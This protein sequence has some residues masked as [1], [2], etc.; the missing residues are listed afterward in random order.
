VFSVPAGIRTEKF[1]NICAGGLP[2]EPTSSV[3][4]VTNKAYE[5]TVSIIPVE[6]SGNYMYN[7]F[8]IHK[9]Y[10]CLQAVYCVSY[11]CR[12]KRH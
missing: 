1:P 8:I 4:T 7:L 12:N 6:D 11:G 3:D 10:I 9:L 5:L 2:I